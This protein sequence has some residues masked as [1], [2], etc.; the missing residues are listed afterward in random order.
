MSVRCIAAHF[1]VLV[2]MAALWARQ[3]FRW[4]ARKSGSRG[5]LDVGSVVL[6]KRSRLRQSFADCAKRCLS[7][8]SPH[9]LRCWWGWLRCGPASFFAGKR[10]KVGVV[11]GST[12]A[13]S[14]FRSGRGLDNLSQT[15]RKDVRPLHRRTFYGVGGDGGVVGPPAFS[16]ASAKKWESW[17][18]RRGQRRSSEAVAA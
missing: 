7:A 6:Q 15:A 9:I 14:F 4:Q 13:A 8:A 12:W 16:L 1:T 18:A 3:L 10:E 5:R 11:V 17:S 2:G